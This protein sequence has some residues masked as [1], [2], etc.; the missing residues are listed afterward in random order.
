MRRRLE[1]MNNLRNKENNDSSNSIATNTCSSA[2]QTDEFEH[3]VEDIT[4]YEESSEESQVIMN[5]KQFCSQECQVDFFSAPNEM[6]KTFICNRYVNDNVCDAETYTEINIVDRLV[7]A[8]NKKKVADKSCGPTTS[9]TDQSVECNLPLV[10]NTKGFFGIQSVKNDDE[11]TDLGGVTFKIFNLFVKKLAPPSEKC[12]VSKENRLFIFFIKMKTG[13]SY[14]ALSVI[15]RV[16]RTTISRIFIEVLQHLASALRD[17]IKW[18]NKDVIQG[19]MPQCFKPDYSNTRIIID[20]T[21]FSVEIPSGVDQR[22]Y[23]YSHYKKGFTIKILIGCAP[24]GLITFKSKC[25]GGRKSDA[26]IT[27]ESGL[28]DLLEENDVILADKGFPDIRTTINEKGKKIVVVMPPFLSNP[29]FTKEETE[30]TYSIARVRIH[31]ERIM[32]RI[33]LF[34][35]LDKVPTNLF[36]YIDEIIHV[37][38]VLVNL[39]PPIIAEKDTGNS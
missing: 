38:C 36:P 25:A 3:N 1:N 9:Y 39:Q 18:F 34:H 33:K 10:H 12:N 28:L 16:H 29:E 2:V 14:S 26:Q 37:I 20:C 11:L 24:N 35:I 23:I 4:D 13:L 15:F 19:M 32:Q 5:E 22:I 7:V 21:E 6:S 8:V 31:I 17:Q 30:Q 27:I